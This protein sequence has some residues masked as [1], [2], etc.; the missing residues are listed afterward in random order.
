MRPGTSLFIEACLV[1]VVVLAMHA[2]KV[3]SN[4]QGF[5]LTFVC[6]DPGI[7]H[8]GRA[9][10][11]L[12]VA[13]MCEPRGGAHQEILASAHYLLALVGGDG[14]GGWSLRR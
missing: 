10:Y 12:A 13:S 14:R 9:S 4:T 8:D 11:V 7:G 2:F 6:A 3:L 5:K 1:S